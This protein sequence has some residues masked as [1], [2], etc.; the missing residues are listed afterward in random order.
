MKFLKLNSVLLLLSLFA[1]V[2]CDKEEFTPL[3]PE[4]EILIGHWLLMH[5]TQDGIQYNAISDRR[6][7]INR[8][9]KG[10][11]GDGTYALFLSYRTED[12]TIPFEYSNGGTWSLVDTDKLVLNADVASQFTV[13]N[14]TADVLILERQERVVT[15]DGKFKNPTDNKSYFEMTPTPVVYTFEKK[16]K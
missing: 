13:K 16:K 9:R 11:S 8:G 14:V 15:A 10:T 12:K 7:E 6:I 5:T 2:G 3:T 1:F 4:K